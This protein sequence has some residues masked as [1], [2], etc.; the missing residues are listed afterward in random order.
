M[1]EKIWEVL[2][3]FSSEAQQKAISRC[4]ELGFDQS[5][6][7]VSLSE[8][9]INLNSATNIL[10]DAIEQNKLIQLP[11]SIQN[12]L[13]T[14]LANIQKYQV[15]LAS[16]ADEVVNLCEAIE[17][18]NTQ[19]WQYGL[20]NLSEEVLGY[21]TKLNQI[22]ALEV[23]LKDANK[24]LRK[25]IKLN[26]SIEQA[27]TDA[28]THLEEIKEFVLSAGNSAI[29]AVE[30]Q[31]EVLETNNQ[32]AAV[33]SAIEEEKNKSEQLLASTKNTD[34]EANSLKLKIDS[35]FTNFTNLK[36]DLEAAQAKQESI[37]KEFGKY[38]ETINGLIGD[39]NRTGMA[40]SFKI[41]GDAL[42]TPT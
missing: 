28:N 13:W 32:A 5:R 19:I 6:G 38:R 11:I 35:L 2:T 23:A 33:I 18:L 16:G 24:E 26:A 12:F 27:N 40:A 3:T 8:S 14:T 31:Q 22:K 36:S 10:K 25:G 29:K 17:K 20:H 30:L 39:A 9:Y 37:F 1:I 41:R 15:S 4:E 42:T 34:E 21:Q 7:V